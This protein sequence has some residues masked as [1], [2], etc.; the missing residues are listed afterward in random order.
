MSVHSLR[1]SKSERS[2]ILANMTIKVD[3]CNPY[4]R[5]RFMEIYPFILLLQ[6]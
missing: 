6:M 1:G 5:W 4:A 3:L 2:L